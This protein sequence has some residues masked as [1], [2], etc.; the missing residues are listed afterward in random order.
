VLDYTL[1]LG[2]TALVITGLVAT[3]GDFVKDQR[4]TVV[5][6]ELGVVGQQFAGE[7]VAID[8]LVQSGSAQRLSVNVTLPSRVAG[9]SYAVNVTAADGGARLALSS[10]NPEVSTV[11][12]VNNDTE[13]ET[14]N[15]QG[16]DI[17]LIYDPGEDLLE[18]QS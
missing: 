4:E 6:T 18:V 13:I 14:T 16:G 10:A 1:A 2:V 11:A 9:A 12:A 3:A 15:V 7:L 5:R 17:E 8:R